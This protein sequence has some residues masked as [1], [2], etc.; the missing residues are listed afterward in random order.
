MVELLDQKTCSGRLADLRA[1]VGDDLRVVLQGEKGWVSV[2]IHH[3]K[4]R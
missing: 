3:W 1:E 4:G 2:G